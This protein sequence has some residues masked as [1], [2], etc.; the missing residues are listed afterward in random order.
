MGDRLPGD[1][2]LEILHI[3]DTHFEG[4]QD[5]K[6]RTLERLRGRTFDLVCFTGDMIER[7][8]G[9]PLVAQ[10][11]SMLTARHGM[12]AVYGNHDLFRYELTDLF[13]AFPRENRPEDDRLNDAEGLRAAYEAA[14]VRL[15]VNEVEE[16]KVHGEP[17]VVAGINDPHTHHHDLD[18]V[19]AALPP[20]D[21][22]HVRLR[23]F[24]S[25]APDPLFWARDRRMDIMLCGHTHGGQICIPGYGPINIRSEVPKA[26]ATG[27]HWVGGTFL[28]VSPGF[29]AIRAVPLRFWA[30]P[31]VTV[32]RL[33]P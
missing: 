16:V 7:S 1:R 12:F 28:H 29:G 33:V 24:L 9:I 30:R 23:V 3:S 32:L 13:Q 25:H 18:A 19:E 11:A 10:C 17:M 2:P 26:Y 4:G 5:W 20:V 21:D 22:E 14:G 6:L 8:C 15:L 27:A 31:E